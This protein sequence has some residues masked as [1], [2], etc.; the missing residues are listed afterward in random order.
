MELLRTF[1]FS[2]LVTNS[3]SVGYLSV[4]RSPEEVLIRVRAYNN[5]D[6]DQYP[7]FSVL[8]TLKGPGTGHDRLVC[9]ETFENKIIF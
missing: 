7:A 6:S 8:S 5:F 3:N 4:F 9:P 2:I 1:E